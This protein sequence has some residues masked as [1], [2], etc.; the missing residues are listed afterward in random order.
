[1]LRK[2]KKWGHN[3][4]AYG[5][6][7]PDY[8]DVGEIPCDDC[9]CGIEKF[10][11]AHG[12]QRP[13]LDNVPCNDCH[14]ELPEYVVIEAATRDTLYQC[15]IRYMNDKENGFLEF[16]DPPMFRIREAV[17]FVQQEQQAVDELLRDDEEGK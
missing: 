3:C 12:C 1:M 8:E 13:D 14:L 4:R 16:N 6:Q 5:C 17:R 7:T 15:A 2:N 9:D 10:C 11:T